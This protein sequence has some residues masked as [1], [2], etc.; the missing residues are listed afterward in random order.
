MKKLLILLMLLFLNACTTPAPSVVTNPNPETQKDY[1]APL[2]LVLT[3]TS[4]PQM[5]QLSGRLLMKGQPVTT[6]IL[7]LGALIKDSNGTEIVASFSRESKV[8]SDVDQNGKFVFTNV[9]PGRYGMVYDLVTNAFLMKSPDRDESL[10]V[11]I[12]ANESLDLG[13]LDYAS[14]PDSSE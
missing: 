8:R 4:D 11:N 9:P 5:G 7:Y 3:P 6:G 1:P 2:T 12:K 10:I 14:F 13:N